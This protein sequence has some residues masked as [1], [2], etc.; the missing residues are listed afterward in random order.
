MTSTTILRLEYERYAEMVDIRPNRER[1]NVVARFAFMVSAR[2]AYTTQAIG[3]VV[4][5]NHATVIHATKCHEMNFRYDAEYRK[6]F[7]VTEAI[8]DGLVHSDE[9]LS[10]AHRIDTVL[11]NIKLRTLVH[12]KTQDIKELESKLH[13]YEYSG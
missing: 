2:R 6:M 10:Q 13:K 5:K 12:K 7:E 9:Y 3:Q 11:E 1:R 4:D 8:I